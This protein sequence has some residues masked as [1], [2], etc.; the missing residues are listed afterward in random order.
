MHSKR[1]GA[2]LNSR[3]RSVMGY[4]LLPNSRPWQDHRL[5]QPNNDKNRIDLPDEALHAG[6]GPA[7]CP[8]TIISV[9]VFRKRMYK[10]T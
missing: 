7:S 1:N 2:W 9:D 4:W 3:C 8:P 10:D 5:H 6:A